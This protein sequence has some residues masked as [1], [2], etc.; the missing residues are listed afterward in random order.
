MKYLVAIVEEGRLREVVR[1]IKAGLAKA[2]IH[3]IAASQV[4][5]HDGDD[6]MIEK[7]RGYEPD[8]LQP[9]A[10]LEIVLEDHA[11]QAAVD[12]ITRGAGADQMGKDSVFLIDLA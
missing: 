12:T 2:D 1:D 8:S 5:C 4:V 10:R 6:V 9:R 11:V 3:R 7:Y